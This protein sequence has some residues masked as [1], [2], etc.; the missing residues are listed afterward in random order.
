MADPNV[1]KI[2]ELTGSSEVGIEDAIQTAVTRASQ[3]VRNL[4]WVEVG[5]IRG[6]VEN[7]K[8]AHYQV[9]MKVGFTLE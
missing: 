7:G 5:Q 6:H 9:V 4:R 2:V 3:T 1:Y 8:I